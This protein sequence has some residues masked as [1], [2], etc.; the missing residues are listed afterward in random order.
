MGLLVT[1]S[2][3]LEDLLTLALLH[4]TYIL[5]GVLLWL[6]LRALWG[7]HILS[8]PPP[9]PPCSLSLLLLFSSSFPPILFLSIFLPTLPD[10]PRPR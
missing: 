6:T 8:A 1:L 3:T 10:S 7:S 2:L 9:S 5:G 4:W